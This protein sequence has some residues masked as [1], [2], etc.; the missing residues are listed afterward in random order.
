MKKII[1]LFLNVLYSVLGWLICIAQV[2]ASKIVNYNQNLMTAL[3][4]LQLSAGLFINVFLYSLFKKK[5]FEKA[6]NYKKLLIID[7]A[8]I[9]LPY[10]LMVL[11]AI[12]Y[13]L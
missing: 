12:L 13:R 4:L 7:C 5:D 8:I 6:R 1:I 2:G 11:L 3:T 9:I 10:F